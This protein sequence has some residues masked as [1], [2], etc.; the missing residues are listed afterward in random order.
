MENLVTDLLPLTVWIASEISIW[1]VPEQWELSYEV[2]WFG[3]VASLPPSQSGKELGRRGS[4]L[5]LG[6][7]QLLTTSTNSPSDYLWPLFSPWSDV[8]QRYSRDGMA[9]LRQCEDNDAPLG[10]MRVTQWSQW[11]WGGMALGLCWGWDSL[12]PGKMEI[13]CPLDPP[14]VLPLLHSPWEDQ[15][16]V[17]LPAVIPSCVWSLGKQEGLG[18]TQGGEPLGA[19]QGL[20]HQGPGKAPLYKLLLWHG[21][22]CLGPKQAFHKPEKSQC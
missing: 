2:S 8:S 22:V 20:G 10:V 1:S 7:L 16:A 11:G 21:P 19:L 4:C 3:E 17:P 12:C 15:L 5:L 14:P 18:G 9:M 13:L 6:M